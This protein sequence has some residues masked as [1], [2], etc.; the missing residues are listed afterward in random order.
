M[1]SQYRSIPYHNASH[2]ADVLHA[3]SF[4]IFFGDCIDQF[5]ELEKL[6]AIIAAVGHDIDHPVSK[7]LFL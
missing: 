5:T 3:F 6:S 4:L 2:A 1:E 7:I